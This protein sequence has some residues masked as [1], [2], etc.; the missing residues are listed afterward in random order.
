[1]PRIDGSEPLAVPRYSTRASA[2]NRAHLA[3]RSV[4]SPGVDTRGVDYAFDPQT[5]GGLLASIAPDRVDRFLSEL[6]SRGAR[7]ATI[8]GRVVSRQGPV[9]VVFR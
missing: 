4:V 9:A 7:A 5:S 3:D 8:V 2:T 1:L 6:R